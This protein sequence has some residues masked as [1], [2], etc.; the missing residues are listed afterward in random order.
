MLRTGELARALGL[1]G[2]AVSALQ[3]VYLF[4]AFFTDGVMVGDGPVT[5]AG[6]AVLGLW[7]LVVSVMMIVRAP[8]SGKTA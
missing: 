1:I 7:P 4:T 3:V 2:L 8:A 5:I 6:F